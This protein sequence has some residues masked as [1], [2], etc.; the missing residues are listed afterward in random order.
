MAQQGFKCEML[1]CSICLDLL[2]DP[3]TIPCGHSYCMSCIRSHWDVEDQRGMHSCPQCRETFIPRPKLV[4][5]TAFAE[6]VEEKKKTGLQT[7]PPDH[8]YAGPEDVACDFCRARKLKAVKSCLQCLA[9]FCEKHLQPHFESTAF[10]K[11]KLVDPSKQLQ[12]NICAHHGEV[13]RIFCRTDQQCI[14]SLCSLEEHRGHDTVSAA[15][16][17]TER[18]KQLTPSRQNIQQRFQKR[19]ED[20]K[21]LPQEVKAIS[22]SADKAVTDCENIFS[23]L[24]GLLQ[25]KSSDI[26]QQIR[27]QKEAEVNRAKELLRKLDQEI[28]ELKTKDA[29]LDRLSQTEDHTQ[30]LRIFSLLSDFSESADSFYPKQRPLRHFEDVTTAVGEMKEKLRSVLLE[31]WPK[32]SRAVAE[33]DVLLPQPEPQP[34]PESRAGFLKHSCRITL[35]PNTV[36]VHLLL[37]EGNRKATYMYRKQRYPEHAE[38]FLHRSQVLSRERLTGRHYW[39]VEWGGSGAYIAVAYKDIS[40]ATDGSEFGHNDLSSALFCGSSSYIFIHN[41]VSTS[42]SGPYSSRIGVY[43]DHKAGILS[44]YSIVSDAMTL[45][46]RVQTTFTQ[47]LYAGF[48]AYHFFF[49]STAE[50]CEL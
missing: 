1:R 3:V 39:E 48:R 43:L 16:E 29:E 45:L 32:I 7:A 14:C 11:H 35:D 44:F 19:E 4:K 27:N 38:R 8:F 12:E 36:N 17:R 40:R 26:K 5:N 21:L 33:V 41:S 42:I 10:E 50:F 6:L 28:T 25:K 37:S 20:V 47:P 18:Q 9:S 23:E 22:R 46:H 34:E 2:K 31:E 13:M 30:F 15:A 49:G 24:I